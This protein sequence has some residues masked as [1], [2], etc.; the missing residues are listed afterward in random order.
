MLAFCVSRPLPAA[1]REE[2]P[3]Q[4]SV[5][6]QDGEIQRPVLDPADDYQASNVDPVTRAILS[7][8]LLGLQFFAVAALED[9]EDVGLAQS[10]VVRAYLA[11]R[12]KQDA[13]NSANRIAVPVWRARSYV[14]IS[15]YVYIVEGDRNKALDWI[16]RAIAETEAGGAER[17]GGETLE[18]I[19]NRLA[20]RGVYERA[21]GVARMIPDT[22]RRVETLQKVASEA[23]RRNKTASTRA[24]AATI[25]QAAFEEAK[26][27]SAPAFRKADILM[28]IGA[29]QQEA[30]NTSAARTTFIAAQDLVTNGPDQGRPAALTRLAAKMVESGDQRNGMGVVRLIPEG[31]DR[32]RA[33]GAVASAMGRHKIDAAVPILRLAVEEAE[34]VGDQT[35]RFEAIRFLVARQTEVGRLKDAFETAF[36]I[37]EDVPRAEALL[38]M[39]LVLIRQNKLAEAETLK[40]YIP[41][42]GMRGQILGPIALGRGIEEDPEG[43]SALLAEALDP[44]GFPNLSAYTAD[45]L[46]AVLR[47]QVKVGLESADQAIF[48]RARALAETLTGNLAQVDALVQ[49]AIAEARRGRV[50]DSQKTIS[51]A[52]RIA[53]GH[54]EEDGFDKALTQISLAQ[55]AAG[56]LLGAYDTAARIPEP[57]SEGSFPRTAAGSFDIPRYRALIRVAAAAGRLGDP[58]FGR[59][60][61]TK[62]AYDPAKAIG[63]AAVA[64]AM[65]N[66]AE[67]LIDVISDIRDQALLS[68]SYR[69]LDQAVAGDEPADGPMDDNPDLSPPPPPPD[70]G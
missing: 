55:L 62:I 29:A 11:R 61:I 53:F 65:S 45:G 28:N 5:P 41:Y 10:G 8:A 16:N 57:S 13:I 50:A 67:D 68:S 20:A 70:D 38:D 15:D 9:D 26:D 36:L 21:T 43:A 40:H 2:T 30:G 1:I 48:N 18:I 58:G 49:V 33:L 54:R 47:A 39:G 63:L 31:A 66:R 6:K 46:N 23:L 32:A 3:N 24:A 17:D 35:D 12:R 34:R 37:T 22:A 25:L 56:D 7:D 44:T 60:V 27:L 52:Y 42:T 69:Y 4:P 51:A 14:W 19:A 59:N 64:I